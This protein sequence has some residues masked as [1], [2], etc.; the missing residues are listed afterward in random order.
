MVS[1]CVSWLLVGAALASGAESRAPN[2]TLCR[3]L[4][5]ATIFNATTITSVDLLSAGSNFTGTS[6]ETSY[7]TAQTNLP[8]LCRVKF[9]TR[10]SS[11][12]SAK[13]EVW[14]PSSWSGR[15]LAVGNGGF[16]GGINYPDV[17]WGVRKGFAT[18]STN[19]GHDSTQLDGTWMLNSPDRLIDFGYRALHSTTVAAKDIVKGYY[20]AEAE[21]AY[22]AGCS[23]GGR[24]GLSAAQRYPQD[25][26][27]V[28]VGSAIASQTNTS[29]WQ[30]YVALNQF[31]NNHSSYIPASMWPTIHEAVLKQCDHLDGIQ[32][33]IIMDPSQCAFHAEVLLCEK[34]ISN[35]S[36]CLNAD[37]V[38]NLERMYRPWLDASSNLIN[39]GI[40]P[41]G[42]LSFATLMNGDEPAFGPEFYRYAVFNASNWNWAETNA[43]T[44]AFANNINPGGCN[45]YNPDMRPFQ[46][47]GGKLIQY[48]GYADPL[49]PSLTAP[50]WYDTLKFFYSSID[51]AD[52]VAA[53]YRLFLVPGMGHCNGGVGGWVIDAA[54]QG[55]V[56]PAD[57]S[58]DHSMLW[59]L[60]DWVEGAG[61]SSNG[62][63]SKAPEMVIGTK[64]LND[65]ASLGVDFE[66]PICRWP[67]VAEYK[68]G[69]V[70]EAASWTCPT[71]RVY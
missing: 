41:S 62:S 30:T 70:A 10:T 71:E 59:S 51:K 9:T 50:A 24:Q 53:F 31:P 6:V 48:H 2:D 56:I 17:V 22:Y 58:R 13:A 19:V 1:K 11:N 63:A 42:E 54:S 5:N 66:R 46:D 29:G 40:S 55:G 38:Q 67:A 49:I 37:Q 20:S 39:P 12:S 23:T 52:E 27:G 14:L 15:F 57:Y 45:A 32:D 65:T 26:N 43:S 68:D 33:G 3:T 21:W 44:I 4:L 60:V 7:D 28:L 8:E 34:S 16:A 69:P 35:S 25:Y 18:L 47:A 61:K 36:A 64:F